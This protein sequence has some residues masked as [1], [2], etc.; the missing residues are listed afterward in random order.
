MDSTISDDWRSADLLC[1]PL[2]VASKRSHV[3]HI[4]LNPPE[5]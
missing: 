5:H 2:D 3:L 4:R 1:V